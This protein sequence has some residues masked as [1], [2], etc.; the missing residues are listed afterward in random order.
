MFGHRHAHAGHEPHI[1][2]VTED[3]ILRPVGVVLVLFGA[4]WAL[5]APIAERAGTMDLPHAAFGLIIAG[6]IMAAIGKRER[7]V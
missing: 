3:T 5:F 6:L 4:T 1:P 2:G 7:Q